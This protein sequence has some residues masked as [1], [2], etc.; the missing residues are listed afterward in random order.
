MAYPDYLTSK[1]RRSSVF[2]KALA[3]VDRSV[4]LGNERN[5]CFVA[6]SCA[7]SCE[8]LSVL[9]KRLLLCNSAFSASLRFVLEA[10][11]SI[12]L[13]LACCENELVS[14]ILAD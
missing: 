13:L 8:H 2:S 7:Y 3:A 6:A 10:L 9:L 5:L 12:E 14:A 11:F 1:R 4:I